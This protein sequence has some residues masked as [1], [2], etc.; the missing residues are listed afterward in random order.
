M[1]NQTSFDKTAVSLAAIFAIVLIALMYFAFQSEKVHVNDKQQT[2][3]TYSPMTPKVSP[4]IQSLHKYEGSIV[5]DKYETNAN[6]P[7][8]QPHEYYV[9]I[10]H[11]P[12]CVRGLPE[13]DPKVIKVR[14][15]KYEYGLFG[16]GDHIT[17]Q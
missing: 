3:K 5:V 2:T 15:S 9:T 13:P 8:D 17:F 12:K 1:S 16:C 6:K 14:V 7:A 10:Y 4:D 11:K